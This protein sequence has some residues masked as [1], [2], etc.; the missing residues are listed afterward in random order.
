[1]ATKPNHY[2]DWAAVQQSDPVSGQ[3]NRVQPP[4]FRQDSGFER[5]EIPPRQWLNWLLW[6][7]SRWIRW[8][9]ERENR[10]ESYIVADLPAASD[11]GAAKI[12]YV[13][14]EAGGAVPAFSDGQDW[15]RMTDRQIVS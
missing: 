15:R 11:V 10:P 4:D 7:A 1:M 14:D 5:R 8:F 9:D 13:T 12:V 3:V 6:V 2:P